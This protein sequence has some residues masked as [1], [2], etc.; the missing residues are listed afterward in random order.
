MLTEEEKEQIKLLLARVVE[1]LD[2][3]RTRLVY[4]QL[5]LITKY[6]ED[7]QKT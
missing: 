3:D 1:W 5:L 6:L 2:D 4:P 7:V